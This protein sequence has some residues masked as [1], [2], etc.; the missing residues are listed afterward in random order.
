MGYFRIIILGLVVILSVY[1]LVRL[2][3]IRQQLLATGEL[4]QNEKSNNPLQIF[5]G[6]KAQP[7]E[8]FTVLPSVSA[9]NE[10]LSNMVT[11]P[12]SI[13]NLRN[14]YA[15][16]ALKQMVIKGAYQTAWNGSSMKKETIIQRLTDGC[17]WLDFEVYS[18]PDDSKEAT[19]PYVATS[20]DA[21]HIKLTGGKMLLVDALSAVVNNA[22]VSPSSPNPED[23]L[24]IM[25]RI[26]PCK[27][28]LLSNYYELIGKAIESTIK[29]QLYINDATGMAETVTGD[30]PIGQLRGKIVLMVDVELAPNFRSIPDCDPSLPSCYNLSKYIHMRAGDGDNIRLNDYNIMCQHTTPPSIVSESDSLTT[31]TKYIRLVYPNNRKFKCAGTPAIAAK[32][33]VFELISNYGVQWAPYPYYKPDKSL[34]EYEVLFSK[35]Q[36][37]FVPLSLALE[38]IASLRKGAPPAERHTKAPVTHAPATAPATALAPAPAPA[39]TTVADLSGLL[40]NAMQQ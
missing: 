2:M 36:S 15:N 37:S 14:S 22:F 30:T 16:L 40:V 12:Q 5:S 28:E 13:Q 9:L 32:D 21:E 7:H 35:M 27:R 24:F 33:V 4:E 3:V 18:V 39:S 31:D 23:P 10:G 26:I 19:T 6:F 34:S 38:H 11:V 17:R 8:N 29:P 1:L 25:L 20:S